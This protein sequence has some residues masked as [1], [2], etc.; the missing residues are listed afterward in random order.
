M[1]ITL[2]VSRFIC[3]LQIHLASGEFL[4]KISGTISPFGSLPSVVTSLTFT[5]NICSHGPFGHKKGH[6]FDIP[7]EMNGCIVGFFAHAGWYVD[8]IGV[9]VKPREEEV[10]IYC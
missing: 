8:A 3:L 2:I 4:C 9:Y 6:P 7:V 5:T 10:R 1:P